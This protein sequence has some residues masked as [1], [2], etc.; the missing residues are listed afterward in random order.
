MGLHEGVN[1]QIRWMFWHAGLRVCKL[2]RVRVGPVELGDLPA[3][4]VHELSS[5]DVK[6]LSGVPWHH[7]P[8]RLRVC[9]RH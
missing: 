5:R 2:V 7:P 8:A 4:T 6:G 9:V 1:G 3:G